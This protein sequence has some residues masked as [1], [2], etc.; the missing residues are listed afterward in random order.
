MQQQATADEGF[1]DLLQPVEADAA[2]IHP[3]PLMHGVGDVDGAALRTQGGDRWLDVGQRVP[4][5]AQRGEQPPLGRQHVGR[6]RGLPGFQAEGRDRGR[7]QRLVLRI[8]ERHAAE[9]ELRAED[10][11]E[12]DR[13][14]L[15]FRDRGQHVGQFRI[16]AR[17]AGDA[18]RN[19]ASIV[20][21]TLQRRAQGAHS[22]AR[23]RPARGERPDRVQLLQREQAR[24]GGQRRIECRL[25]GLGNG[26]PVR[27][28]IGG[29]CRLHAECARHR[30]QNDPCEVSEAAGGQDHVSVAEETRNL[31]VSDDPAQAI[32]A[33]NG[34]TPGRL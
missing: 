17:M 7:R 8:V 13:R 25:A 10:E 29:Q 3:R 21:E 19:R 9:G 1:V 6:D 34:G 16:V 23:A 28:R 11:G 14:G 15:P 33:S 30:Q 22:P 5:L 20:A 27:L 12:P 32:P 24:G 31:P 2:E 26:G 18:D 4:V